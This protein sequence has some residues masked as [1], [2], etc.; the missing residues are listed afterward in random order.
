[1][2]ELTIKSVSKFEETNSEKETVQMT[3]MIISEDGIEKEIILS[4]NGNIKV[5]S[6]V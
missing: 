5:A 1:M 3:K 4:G 6:V 2:S